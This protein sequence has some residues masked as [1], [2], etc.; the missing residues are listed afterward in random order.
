LIVVM[1]VCSVKKK[2]SDCSLEWADKLKATPY[3]PRRKRHCDTSKLSVT[4]DD[5]ES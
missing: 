1:Q 2:R 3:Y 4:V 5:I